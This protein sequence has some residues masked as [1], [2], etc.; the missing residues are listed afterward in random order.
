MLSLCVMLNAIVEPYLQIAD[1][2]NE[3]SN[4]GF[5]ID[6]RGWNP[7]RFENAQAHSCKPTGGN[8][9]GGTDQEFEPQNG[10][11]IGRALADGHCLEARSSTAGSRIDVP[12]CDDAA[13]LQNFVWD[14]T[15]GTLTLAGTGLCLAVGATLRP[16]N[17][18]VARDLTVESCASTPS[19]LIVWFVQGL[20]PPPPSPPP[21]PLPSPLPSALPSALHSAFALP[22]SPHA[23]TCMHVR[24]YTRIIRMRVCMRACGCRARARV[25]VCACVCALPCTTH[26]CDEA[27]A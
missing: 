9:G 14:A 6:L 8:A 5:C 21:S 13:P 4:Y 19:S 20:S 11:I 3:P 15:A 26:E 23:A 25:C 12:V 10:A 1:N 22:S 18:Y 24:T 7:V 27:S 17:S 2:L 16:A